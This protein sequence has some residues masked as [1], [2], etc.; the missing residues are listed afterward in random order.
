VIGA[1]PVAEDDDDPV[2]ASGPRRWFGWQVLLAD[3]PAYALLA[4]SHPF[5]EE[6]QGVWL[7]DHAAIL[8]GSLVAYSVAAP[9]VH[10]AHGQLGRGFGSLGLH[11]GMATAGVLSTAPACNMEAVGCANGNPILFAWL[12]GATLIDAAAL[13]W[14]RTPAPKR[15]SR[16]HAAPVASIGRGGALLGVNGVF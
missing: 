1:G 2:E 4:A 15:E 10:F 3:L 14:K 9:I 16:A 6:G 5:R 8:G 13:S 12:A 11:L 7:R